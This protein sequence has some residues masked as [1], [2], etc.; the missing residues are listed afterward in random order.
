MKM[1]KQLQTNRIKIIFSG[2]LWC[3]LTLIGATQKL[4]A[5]CT[6]GFSQIIVTIVP[7]SYPNETSWDIKDTTNTIIASGLINS[8]TLC[9]PTGSLLHFTIHDTY[10]DGICCGGFGNG[11]YNV[12]LDGTLVASGGQ[13]AF[14]DTTFFNYPT[15]A[16]SSTL[17]NDYQQLINYCNNT[18]VL[19]PAQINSIAADIQLNHFYMADNLPVIS[20]AFNLINCYETNTGPLFLNAATTGGFPN[21]P[22]ALDGFEYHRAIYL[23]QQNLFDALFTENKVAQFHT[24]LQ[25]KKYL[26]SNYFPGTCPLPVDSTLA[27]TTTVNASMAANWGNPTAWSTI[28]AR[29]P[30]GYYLSPGTIGKVKVPP[31]MVNA[32]YKI[33]VG[34]HPLMN[35]TVHPTVQ[36]FFGIS[37]TYSITD[38]VTLIANPF[39]GGIYIVVP[40]L[41]SA[42]LQQVEL[43]NVVPAPFFSKKSFNNTTLSQWQTVQRN[44]PA[45]WADFESE[46]FMMQVPTNFI[47]NY[48]DPVTLMADW[49]ARM[50]VVSN[51]MGYPLIHNNQI[52]Y[53]M[54]DV[55][56]M[57]GGYGVGFPQ[58]N[59]P[60]S[61]YT[62]QNGNSQMWFLR[63]GAANMWESEFHEL[64]HSQS[65]GKFVGEEEAIVN[66]LSAA[67]YNQLYGMSIDSAFGMSFNNEYWRGRDQSA[68]NW[69]I[70]HNFRVG[71]PMNI[72]N[73]TR[74][75]VRYQHRGYG[76]Y[77][78]IAALFGWGVLHN[79]YQ[80]I[81]LDYNNGV[82]SGPLGAI[83]NRILRL[84]KAAGADLRPLI[85][86]W[87]WQ[88][89]DSAALAVAIDTNNLLPSPLICN[90]L[91]HYLSIIPMDSTQFS[92]Q[93]QV[94]FNGPVPPG[95]NPDY[96]EGWY[97]VWLPQYN[98]L[99]GDSAV[100][101]LQ[102]IINIYFPN[103]SCATTVNVPHEINL[104]SS[105]SIFPN[106][107]TGQ[108][109]VSV[110]EDNDEITVTDIL[111]Q[112]IL[113]TK[114]TQKTT[115]LQL[116]KNGVYIIY[117]KTKQ[118]TTTKKLIVNR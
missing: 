46:K 29:R 63:P 61:P 109:T 112:Q 102:H 52:L 32:G 6:T 3:S 106:P 87:G 57:Y 36:R 80:Q 110:P 71:N 53:I 66:L 103:G 43:T 33:L 67:I 89:Q 48:S 69:M 4:Q 88:P 38:T 40:N 114:A 73:T 25:G 42:G 13:F 65:M 118:G 81:N 100:T 21:A 108:F 26:T 24:Y 99:H 7:D 30:T 113:I 49:D 101:A 60:Y 54:P 44:N 51:L 19:S 96:E 56:I 50:D 34:A 10:G 83:D 95:G 59:N 105:V 79:Y 15:G 77:V 9:Y 68:I 111:G 41:A 1:K 85:H 104:N 11:S 94:Y 28:P 90:R 107:N 47:N 18:S 84:S 20:A 91:T 82:P 70:T 45:P 115:N 23:V 74:D 97:N 22:G 92:Q 117:V 37:N 35:S 39:G 75:E 98:N 64:G 55:Q 93:A 14:A 62:V 58:I 78:E 2:L 5:Q 72:S 17:I 76:K 27:Y 86:F 116:D 16:F 31:A 12:Y 8:D